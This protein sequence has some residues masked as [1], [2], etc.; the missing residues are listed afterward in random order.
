MTVG[1][2]PYWPFFDPW[3]RELRERVEA[4]AHRHVQQE[5][6]RDPEAA[7]RKLVR[8]MGQAGWLRYAIAG[9]RWGAASD[10]LEARALCSIREILAYHDPLADAAFALQGLGSA[11]ISLFGTEALRRRYLPGVASGEL[12]AAFALTEPQAGSDAAN[13]RCRAEPDGQGYRIHGMKTFVS[14]GGVA[15]FYVVFA[16]TGEQKGAAGITAFVVDADNPGLRVA[17]RIQSLAEHPLA[18]VQFEDCWVPGDWR[19]GNPGEGFRVA[20]TTLDVFRASVA[21]AAVGLARRALHEAVRRAT[22]RE[23]FGGRLADLQLTQAKLADMATLV[24]ASALLTYRAAWVYD[25]GSRVTRESAMAKLFATEAA[26]RVVDAAVQVWGGL[27][28]TRGTTVEALYR[29]VRSLRIYEG[30]TEV[31]QLVVARELLRAYREQGK[32]GEEGAGHKS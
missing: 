22:E 2:D 32:G 26:Q 27:G 30:A 11:P 5:R 16:R 19:V 25:Q 18:T 10:R 14:N 23:M 13:L 17:E 3:H 7:T 21:A 24:D 9:T 28:V 15:D 31:Q 20:M 1:S 8:E 29:E 12:I 4:W 6:P